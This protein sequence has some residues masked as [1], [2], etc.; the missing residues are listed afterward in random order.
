[1]VS[2][3]RALPFPL[4]PG[5]VM[6]AELS[7]DIK[8][9]TQSKSGVALGDLDP[10]FGEQGKVLLD[11]PGARFK[12]VHGMNLTPA[13]KILVVGSTDPAEFIVGCL[14]ETGEIDNSFGQNGLMKGKFQ[15]HASVGGFVIPLSDGKILV[16][17]SYSAND[18]S[19]P[20]ISRLLPDGNFDTAFAN[21]GTFVFPPDAIPSDTRNDTDVTPEP[22]RSEGSS[23]MRS[24][25]LPDGRILMSQVNVSN[26][27]K[28][29]LLIRLTADGLLDSSFNGTGFTFVR[30]PHK[31]VSRTSVLSFMV[32]DRTEIIVCGQIEIEGR[33][34]Q[35]LLARYGT[36]GRP[37]TR[38][39]SEGTGFIALDVD[40]HLIRVDD[41]VE[42][43][44]GRFVGFGTLTN[45]ETAKQGAIAFGRTREGTPDT[46]FN[47]GQI[48]S[49]IDLEVASEWY[50]AAMMMASNKFV[51]TGIAHDSSLKKQ[52]ILVGRYL[53]SGELDNEFSD[54]R[55][56]M[57]VG[58]GLEPRLILQ[59]DNKILVCYV[60][61]VLGSSE[62]YVVRLMN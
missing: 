57:T 15:K 52:E 2:A 60:H 8:M 23:G 12:S 40:P 16:G 43:Q 21:G 11:F 32:T 28:F 61:W 7:G 59:S 29:G 49:V 5:R 24:T 45:L 10:S 46:R 55:G 9:A 4:T 35:G 30:Y 51:A 20:A 22:S 53:G 47:K 6:D 3:E 26:R 56:W 44:D 42:G 14:T 48:A 18:E 25:L 1:M 17:G 54:G 50:S 13:G 37:D 58:K 34:V 33:S 27:Y 38:F 62:S 31:N 41:I 39:G 19:L 36:N